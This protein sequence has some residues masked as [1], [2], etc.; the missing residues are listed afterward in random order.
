MSDLITYFKFT[1]LNQN[2]EEIDDAQEIMIDLGS[3]LKSNNM[4]VTVKNAAIDLFSDGSIRHRWVDEDGIARF[5]AVKATSGDVIDEELIDVYATYTDT[6]P[7]LS[8]QTDDYLLFTGVINKGKI[9]YKADKHTIELTCVDRTMVMLDRLSVPQSYKP[10]DTSAPN[11]VGW[12]A[13]Y[14]IQNVIRNTVDTIH[15]PN[16]FNASG[17]VV[18]GGPFLVDVR[19]FSD[20]IISSGTTTS[21]SAGK[22]IDSGATFSTDGVEKDDWVRNYEDNTYAYVRSVDS[23][24]QITLSKDIFD[25]GDGY[26]VSDGF[27][28]DRRPDS[29]TFPYISFSQINKPIAEAIKKM[30]QIENMNST[31]EK[32]SGYI[33]KRGAKFF[34]DKKNRFHWYIPDNSPTHIMRVGATAA[35]SPDSSFHLIYEVELENE[36]RNK[37]NFI[38]FKAGEDMDGLQIKSYA[39]A[40]FSG[41][42]NTKD[43]LRVWEN[44]ARDMKGEDERE[45]NIVKSSGDTYAYPVSY[46]PLPSGVNYPAWDRQKRDPVNDA[47]YNANFKEEAIIRGKAKCQSIFQN[48]SN[49][50]WAGKI[51]LRGEEFIVGD[52]IQF[53]SKAHGI[54]DIL[55]RIKQVTHSFTPER[56]WVTSL[57]VEEDELEAEVGL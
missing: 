42:P 5:K 17:E 55:V 30:S 10:D 56:G 48:T 11:G 26:A 1:D 2:T 34:L 50:R 51:Q 47:G 32:S 4:R 38:I 19:L 41:M 53:T 8:V 31:A 6:N 57:Q 18:F 15:T 52:L 33:V 40:Q 3:N 14:V 28:Q 54:S 44:I 24:T 23:E 39:R 25:S 12:S 27:V 9:P 7:T 45:G 21:A 46:T 35:I 43:A 16:Q 37:V 49:P 20:S 36:V 29:S 22:L 13:P